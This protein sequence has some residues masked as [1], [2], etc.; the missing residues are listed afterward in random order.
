MGVWGQLPTATAHSPTLDQLP[1]LLRHATRLKVI[2]DGAGE[3]SAGE[4]AVISC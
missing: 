3:V 1:A 4:G 2:L